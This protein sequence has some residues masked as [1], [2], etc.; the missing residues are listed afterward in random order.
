MKPKIVKPIKLL[1]PLKSLK[2]K[3]Y[4]WA[5]T[6]PGEELGMDDFVNYAKFFLCKT[7]KTLWK[8]PIWDDYTDEEIMIEYF[9]HLFT[10]D[11]DAR[12]KF[13]VEINAGTEIYGEDIY[14]WLDRKVKEN[15]AEN[16]KVLDAMPEKISFSPDTGKDK[17]E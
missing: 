3:G 10:I 13:E 16:R 5:H 12:K 7:S 4:C 9:A 6:A 11:V 17:E 14:D 15:Q 2:Y 1:D 8:D